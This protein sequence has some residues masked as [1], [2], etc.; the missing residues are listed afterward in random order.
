MVHASF[1]KRA[2]AFGI[3][4]L[5]ILLLQLTLGGLTIKL[6][7]YTCSQW[8][9]LPEYQITLLISQFCGAFFFIGYF[10]MVQG[11]W[12]QTV[13]KYLMKIITLNSQTHQPLTLRES[14][15]RS[16]SYLLSSWTYG[17]GFILPLF[18]KDK[19]ALH[20]LLCGSLVAVKE[21]TSN[22][23]S[24]QLALPFLASV[25]LLQKKRME[26]E[27]EQDQTKIAQ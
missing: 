18:R 1:F 3:D 26:Q 15:W 14:Y 27:T 19:A 10:S 21:L 5:A 24:Q 25:H 13:G 8:G 4:M 12:G 22:E 6:Y 16:L 7:E 23:T 20:D 11:I 17:V 2:S 9:F